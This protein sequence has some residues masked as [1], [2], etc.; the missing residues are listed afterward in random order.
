MTQARH[1][2]EEDLILHYYGERGG[3]RRDI[4]RHLE[5]CGACR[6]AYQALA[7]TLALV[8][9]EEPPERGE[10]Y[11]LEVW[12]RIR[13]QLPERD[14]A[15]WAAAGW[16][17]RDRLAMAAGALLLVVGAFGVGRMWPRQPAPVPAAANVANPEAPGN[18]GAGGTDVRERILLSAVADHLDRSER[19][20]T[21]LMNVNDR[22][23]STEQA[24]AGDL[25]TAS[26][27]YR[28][29]AEDVGEPLLASVLDEIERGLLEIVHSPSRIS[30][31]A[32]DQLRRRIDA[33]AL[34]FKVRVMSDELRR[35]EIPPAA[36]PFPQPSTSTT[37]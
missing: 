15:W 24:W 9:P 26:R 31:T 37:S 16:F 18:P 4:E 21:E 13:H 17:G 28:Q 36:R 3:A 33:A 23:I 1:C 6:T 30:A 5:S 2:T 20:L 14:S 10:Q 19:M 27:L 11:G 8:T 12:Q 25:L 7:G 32:L 34:L 35:R 29:D 22:D